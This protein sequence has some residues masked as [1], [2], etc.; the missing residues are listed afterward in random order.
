MISLII[1][2]LDDT[3][4]D[5]FSTLTI[6]AKNTYEAMVKAGMKVDSNEEALTYLIGLIDKTFTF[7]DALEQFVK[8]FSINQK[9]LDI[10]LD[11]Y[12]CAPLDIKVKPIP[13]AMELITE[14]KKSNVLAI[15]TQ[16]D[17]KVQKKKLD[18]AGFGKG[19]F[20]KVIYSAIY[21]KTE[22]YK[23]LLKELNI[24]PE[25]CLVCGDK[26]KTDL[27]PAKKLG[28]KTVHFK[29]GRGKIFLPEE[30][31][32]DYIID[33]LNKVEEIIKELK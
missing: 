16:G 11:Y 2:D 8:H 29:W 15:V 19:T 24:K 30:N 28:M 31:Q 7:K 27:L 26:F 12:Y 3:L 21:D 18:E 25:N 10:A 20:K 6:K 9:Y 33:N 17:G 4:I 14:L 22:S 5:T 13:E 32:V 1:F 23:K